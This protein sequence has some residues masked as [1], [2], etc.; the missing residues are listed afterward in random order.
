MNTQDYIQPANDE[1]YGHTYERFLIAARKPEELVN[2]VD[3]MDLLKKAVCEPAVGSGLVIVFLY[4]PGGMGKSRIAEEVLWRAGNPEMRAKMGPVP[5]DHPDWDWAKSTNLVAPYLLDMSH[6]SYHFNQRFMQALKEHLLKANPGLDFNDYDRAYLEY[7]QRVMWAVGT[8]DVV[9]AAKYAE[10]AFF[11]CYR[12]A[13]TKTERLVLILD[14]CE[15]LSYSHTTWL[16]K[17]GLIAQEELPYISQWLIRLIQQDAF[18]NT[19]LI[20]VG[21]KKEGQRFFELFEENLSTA[22]K[23]LNMHLEKID[24]RGF[25][26]EETRD[27]FLSLA[28]TWS[29]TS[30]KHPQYEYIANDFQILAGDEQRLGVLWRYTGGQPVRLALYSDLI[31]EGRGLS[32]RLLD[33]PE[34]ALQR[35]PEEIFAAVNEDPAKEEHYHDLLEPIQKSIESSF[36]HLLFGQQGLRA[37]ILTA[38]VR[39]PRG[40][41]AEQLYILLYPVPLEEKPDSDQ[42]ALIEKELDTLSILAIIKIRPDGRL[43]LQD[44]VYKI[45]THVMAAGEQSREDEKAARKKMYARLELYARMKLNLLVKERR[46]FFTE[47]ERNLD[48]SDPT[49][50]HRLILPKP[51]GR[52]EERRNKIFDEIDGWEKEDLHYRLLGNLSDTMNVVILELIYFYLKANHPTDFSSMQE[53]Y[54]ILYD[55]DLLQFIDLPSNPRMVERGETPIQVLRRFMQQSEVTRWLTRFIMSSNYGEAMQ[56]LARVDTF[57]ERMDS[58]ADRRSW[59]HTLSESERQC[60]YQYM[61]ILDGEEITDA[62]AKLEEIAE[63]LTVLVNTSYRQPALPDEHGFVGHPAH[64]RV[65]RVLSLAY[66]TLGYGYVTIGKLRTSMHFYSKALAQLRTTESRVQMATILN[67]LSRALSDMGRQRARRVC[68]DALHLRKDDG[69]VGP[70]AYSYNTLALIDNDQLRPDLAWTE[71]ATAA[72]Y[73]RQIGDRRGLGLSLIQLGEALRRLAGREALLGRELPSDPKKFYDAAEQALDEAVRIFSSGPQKYEEVRLIEANIELGCLL[74]DRLARMEKASIRQT[75]YLAAQRCLTQAAEK[76]RSY[77]NLRLELDAEVNQAWTHYAD[78]EFTKAEE[79]LQRAE[80][81]V[82][83]DGLITES[84]LPR[85]DRDDSYI[86]Q[87]MS[88]ICGLRGKMAMD[89]FEQLVKQENDPLPSD[90]TR[91]QRHS[92]SLKN[93]G[94]QD[95][96]RMSVKNYV[97]ALGYAQVFSPRSGALTAIY[98]QLYNY[99]KGFNDKELKLFYQFQAIERKKYHLKKLVLEDLGDLGEFLHECIGEF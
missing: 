5:A 57:I 83:S 7:Q 46:D 28:R 48:L 55:D 19:T 99:L 87:Q 89:T 40:L 13:A 66:N 94:V 24:L 41:N 16:V 8:Q 71:A 84:F 65:K 88:K 68:L 21:R 49:R 56:F 90:L 22:G 82:P 42:L 26:L 53:I 52:E 97:L 96:L 33:S 79:A 51:F 9:A 73:F 29:E 14:T 39:A 93:T 77:Q 38:L 15:K 10:Q 80:R 3:E 75:T 76:A 81:L 44:E 78:R 45:Y 2:R 17:E 91:D 35:I 70:V 34:E 32:D 54:H 64:E 74:R 85:P 63:K 95:A 30:K 25:N 60:W 36:I 1:I 62:L 50:A 18:P 43:G 31:V 37:G 12:H 4:G 11:T 72:A 98:D 69:A 58:E 27:Y 61:R 67:N 47:D 59:R 23:N 20:L 86:F 6:T 92:R